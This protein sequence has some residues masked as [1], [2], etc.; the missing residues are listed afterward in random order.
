MSKE[1]EI[2]VVSSEEEL[3]EEMEKELT[4]EVPFGITEEEQ[5]ENQVTNEEGD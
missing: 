1:T 2:K 5:L 3:V 4:E